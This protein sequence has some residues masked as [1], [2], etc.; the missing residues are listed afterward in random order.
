M[1]KRACF[2]QSS[3]WFLRAVRAAG[4]GHCL[5]AAQLVC[6]FNGR[7]HAQLGEDVGAVEL[8]RALGDAQMVGDGLVVVAAEQFVEYLTFTLA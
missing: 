6:Q 1:S 2:P 4:C 3:T 8:H 5:Q 7:M